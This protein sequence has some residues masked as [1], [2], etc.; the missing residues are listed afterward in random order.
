M[1][2]EQGM[3]GGFS[4]INKRYSEASK[5]K[6]ILYRNMNNLNGHATSQYLPYGG[7]NGVKI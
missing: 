5:N 7:F 4:Y 3:L 1:F 2:F 6:Y